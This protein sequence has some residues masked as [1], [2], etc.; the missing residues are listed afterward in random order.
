MLFD[1]HVHDLALKS[2]KI[3]GKYVTKHIFKTRKEGFKFNTDLARRPE[4][5]VIILLIKPSFLQ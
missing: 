4:E 5:E 3:T 1:H 2:P